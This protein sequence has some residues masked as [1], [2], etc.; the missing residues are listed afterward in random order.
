MGFSVFL[1]GGG[2][3]SIAGGLV[4][5]FY[6]FLCL[7]ILLFAFLFWFWFGGRGFAGI[8]RVIVIYIYL[9]YYNTNN[10]HGY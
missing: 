4:G 3:R 10:T 2:G 8:R 1:I 9:I 5:G 6:F 7:W